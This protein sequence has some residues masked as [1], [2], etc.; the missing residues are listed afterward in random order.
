MLTLP[1]LNDLRA[2]AARARYRADPVAWV[3]EVLGETIWSKQREIFN[4]LVTY[5]KVAVPSAFGTGKCVEI[6][7]RIALYDGRIVTAKD[8]LG[9]HFVV[10]AFTPTG[11]QVPAIAWATDNGTQPVCRV[12]TDAGRQI[13]R[14]GNHPLYAAKRVFTRVGRGPQVTVEGWTAISDLVV[15]DLILVP[16]QLHVSGGRRIDDDHVKLLGYLLGDGGTTTSITFTQEDGPAKTEF[17]GIVNRLGGRTTKATD[18]TLRCTGHDPTVFANGSNPILNLARDWGLFGVKSKDKSFPDFVWELPNDQLSM[19]LNR[20]FACDG[21]ACTRK[22]TGSM[23]AQIGICL[24]SEKMIRDVEM[25]LLRL[26]ICGRVRARKMKC[27]GKEFPAWEWAITKSSAVVQFAA[28]VGIFGKEPQVDDAR[29]CAVSMSTRNATKW[30][31]IGAPVGYHWQ[32]IKTIESL[33]PAPTVTISVDNYHTFITTVVEHNSFIAARAAVWWVTTH[34]P[35]EAFVITTAST[36]AQV[37]SILWREMGRA[38]EKAGSPGRMNQTEWHMLMPNGREELV[39]FGRKPADMDTTGFQGLHAPY[40]LVIIDEAAGVPTS[41]FEGAEALV[42]NDDSRILAIGNPEDAVSEFYNVCKPGSGWHVIRIPADCTPNFTGEHVPPSV[43]HQLISRSWVEFKRRKW[44]EDNPMWIAKVLA[45]FPEVNESGLIPISWIRAAQDRVIVPTAADVIHLGIDVGGGGN[46]SIT[47]VRHGGRVRIVRK[48][49][50]PDTMQV[51]GNVVADMRTY[52][53]SEVKIDKIGI[54]RGVVDRLKELGKPITG[55]N[56][57][58]PANDDTSFINVRAEGYWDLRMAFQDGLID[59]DPADEDLAAQL[60][61]LKYE[62]GSAGRIAIESKDKIRSRGGV[63]PDEADAVMLAWLD[64]TKGRRKRK[65]TWGRGDG[66]G[67]R[68]GKSAALIRDTIGSSLTANHT[69]AVEHQSPPVADRERR[70]QNRLRPA[71][72]VVST[73][74]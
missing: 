3:T 45:E 8:L 12:T 56:V 70:V 35:G 17:E 67:K 51:A 55:V 30:H 1:S 61:S 34:A 44:G 74:R 40:V 66:G 50:N 28:I 22:A 49:S 32:P 52:T 16:D 11:K 72:R 73:D 6:N 31:T 68:G 24:A 62:R 2:S 42:I 64:R 7:E 13:T 23:Q 57:A 37:R 41:I 46:K 48:D 9:R 39:A 69:S 47:A 65:A 38:F 59:I 43:A 33:S 36:Y 10:P 27:D 29:T 54:G 5:P 71:G 21:W 53:P 15:G 58:L 19:L 20:L 60:V 4:A 63:S 26:G 25:A 14:T 18:T